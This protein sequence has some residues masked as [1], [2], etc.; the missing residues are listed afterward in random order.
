ML[1]AI[2]IKPKTNWDDVVKHLDDV[3]M[4][5]VMVFQLS[6]LVTSIDCRT[7]FWR[8]KLHEGYAS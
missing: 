5:L 6:S 4:V 7:W 8:P 1:P 2:G 3:N